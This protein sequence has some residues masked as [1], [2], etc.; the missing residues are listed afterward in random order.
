MIESELKKLEELT[1]PDVID[2]LLKTLNREGYDLKLI[3]NTEYLRDKKKLEALKIKYPFVEE[4]IL[5]FIINEDEVKEFEKH[6]WTIYFQS[7]SDAYIHYT[8]TKENVIKTIQREIDEHSEYDMYEIYHNH[9]PVDFKIKTIIEIYEDQE[10]GGEIITLHEYNRI[11]SIYTEFETFISSYKKLKFKQLE[12]EIKQFDELYSLTCTNKH[13]YILY[14][15]EWK[16][17]GST[18]META[19]AFDNYIWNMLH[20]FYA[21]NLEGKRNESD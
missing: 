2:I 9:K 14:N 13:Y 3:D 18:L 5:E 1:S 6:N 10:F 7:Q 15:D 11:S 12:N 17:K 20:K 4:I 21:K 8:N 19:K 16:V